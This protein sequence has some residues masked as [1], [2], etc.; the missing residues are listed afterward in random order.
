MFLTPSAGTPIGWGDLLHGFASAGAI[1]R[2]EE[3]L[4]VWADV[5][6]C[7]LV[8]SGTTAFYLFLEAL[9]R[10]SD[11]T[12]VVL[13]AYTAPSLLLPIWKAGLTPVLCDMS[14]ETFN[15]DESLL[16]RCV[17][18]ETLCVL[19]VHMFGLPCD[20]DA[21]C[22]IAGGRGSFVLE[23]AA[24][25]MGSRL[26]GRMAGT[27]GDVGFFSLNR[28]KNFS[29]LSGGC[30]ISDREDLAEELAR[31]C[32]GLPA[33]GAKARAAMAARMMGLSLAV[34]PAFYTLL[35]PL[36]ARFKYTT[37]HTEF[38][39]FR[40]TSMQAGVGRSLFRRAEGIFHRRRENGMFLHHALSGV[41]GV[42]VPKILPNSTTVFNQFPAVF[43][44]EELRDDLHRRMRE[45]GVETT[46][47][48]PE[49][50][51]RIYDLGYDLDA[52][53]FPSATYLARRLLLIPTHPMIGRR[54]LGRVIDLI[55]SS[56]R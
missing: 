43:A 31:G 14:P 38:D 15:M 25:A 23:D 49:P 24:S 20:M 17:G 9:K 46:I 18:E 53:P 5:S 51:H 30:L 16:D 35:Y 37:L 6:W 26:G 50:I 39:S 41:Q 29:T 28:G 13:P 19:A 48:Y 55:T 10:F 2:F 56:V 3:T 7:R 22:R 52:D 36:V 21:V 11:R 12:E 8:N 44:S 34:R 1:G 4:R 54:R 45:V 40:Y 42:R 47:L 32:E 27:F 33:L